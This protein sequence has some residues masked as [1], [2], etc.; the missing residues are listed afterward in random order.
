MLFHE[1]TWLKAILGI[2]TLTSPVQLRAKWD[3]LSAD[4]DFC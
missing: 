2:V 1:I 3:F 4:F